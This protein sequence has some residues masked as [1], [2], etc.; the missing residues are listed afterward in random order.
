MWC[1]F[2]HFI[3]FADSDGYAQADNEI[4][5]A[6]EGETWSKC[7][8]ENGFPELATDGDVGP[9]QSSGHCMHTCNEY[10]PYWAVDMKT[11]I[12]LEKVVIASRSSSK[13]CKKHI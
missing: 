12:A 6:A 13:Y 7:V 3:V 5:R 8:T 4:N 1:Y 11:T 2:H 10:R 9:V